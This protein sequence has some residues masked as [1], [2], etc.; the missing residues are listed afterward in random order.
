[1]LLKN[2]KSI[3]NVQVLRIQT[4]LSISIILVIGSCT[5]TYIE[6]RPVKKIETV[7]QEISKTPLNLPEPK[8]VPMEKVEWV[9]ITPDNQEKV[10]KKLQEQ[11]LEP[12]IFGLA[13]KNYENLAT[14]FSQIRGYILKQKELI[15]EYKVYYEYEE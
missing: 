8:A 10:F 11:G 13:G 3:L 12:V 1:M 4:I 15:A 14:N 5:G 2:L 6:P 7:V 9:L